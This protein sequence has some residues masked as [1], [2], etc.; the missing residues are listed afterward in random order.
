MPARVSELLLDSTNP[1]SL[2]AIAKA[3][4]LSKQTVFRLK[5]DPRVRWLRWTHG[6]CDGQKRVRFSTPRFCAAFFEPLS[7]DAESEILTNPI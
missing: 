3:E 4:G 1:P 2:S 7:V 6:V 5:Q